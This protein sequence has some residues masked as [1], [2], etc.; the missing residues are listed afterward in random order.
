MLLL[1]VCRDYASRIYKH[2]WICKYSHM[3][4]N[5]IQKDLAS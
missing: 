4:E 3:Q 2:E 5:F 1:L